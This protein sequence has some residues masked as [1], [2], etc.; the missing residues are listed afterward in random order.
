MFVCP[1]CNQNEV[2][3]F[4]IDIKVLSLL[5]SSDFSAVNKRLGELWA[6]VPTTHKYVSIHFHIL[7]IHSNM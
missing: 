3:D 1:A 5:F 4:V 2:S 7:I 6:L